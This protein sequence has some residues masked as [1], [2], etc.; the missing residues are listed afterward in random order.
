MESVAEVDEPRAIGHSAVRLCG[1]IGHPSHEGGVSHDAH[2]HV[3]RST[4]ASG[5][6]QRATSPPCSAAG[7]AGETSRPK[8]ARCITTSQCAKSA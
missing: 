6:T 1:P 3:A 2:V 5:S 8:P 7:K 4:T